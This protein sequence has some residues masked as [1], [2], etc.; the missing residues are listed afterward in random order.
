MEHRVTKLVLMAVIWSLGAT[1]D[2]MGR[3]RFDAWLRDE[4]LKLD[5]ALLATESDAQGHVHESPLALPQDGLVYD[6]CFD[7]KVCK[8]CC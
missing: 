7:D 1:C 8:W 4:V 5:R 6:F 2:A 3:E